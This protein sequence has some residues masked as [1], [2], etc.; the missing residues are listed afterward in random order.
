[1]NV[2]C[3][4][5]L[6]VA[7]AGAI[8]ISCDDKGNELSLND[9]KDED[10]RR[11]ADSLALRDSLKIAYYRDSVELAQELA[12]KNAAGQVNYSVV[13]VNGSA[14]S[15]FS[16]GRTSGTQ[17]LDGAT[18]SVSQ[19]GTVYSETTDAT[20]IASFKGFLRG[21][22]V[23]SVVRDGFTSLNYV[24]HVPGD[25]LTTTGTKTELGNMVPIFEL[26]GE[27]TATVS[28]KLTVDTDLTNKISEAVPE[29]TTITAAIDA[30]DPGFADKFFKKDVVG[31]N[32]NPYTANIYSAV[33]NSNVIGSTNADGEYTITIPSAVDGLPMKFAYSQIAA[34]QKLFESSDLGLNNVRSYR[35]L[36]GPGIAPT[37]VPPAGGV[38]VNILAGSGASATAQISEDGKVERIDVVR[39]GYGYAGT[40]V[41]QVSPSPTPGGI[42]ATASA[43]VV[44][45]VITAITLD[46]PGT[47]YTTAPTVSVEAGSGAS[48]TAAL[49]GTTSVLSARITNSG[50]GYTTAPNVTFTA[51]PGTGTTATGTAN[52]SN[53][54]VTS[55]TI[56]DAGSGYDP[57]AL[58]SITIDAPPAGG[59][60]A[61]AVALSSGS[62]VDRV[63]VLNNGA[64]YPYAPVVTFSAPDLVNG[65]RA[66]GVA[67]YDANIQGVVGVEITNPGSGYTSAPSIAFNPGTGAVLQ[68]KFVGRGV[69]SVT[70]NDGGTKYSAAPLV[71]FEPAPGSGG[72]G[73]AGTAVVVN[74]EVVAVEITSA[75]NGYDA[76]PLISFVSGQDGKAYAVVDDGKVT[77]I[78]LVDGGFGYT[79]APEIELTA[80]GG[81][82]SGATATATVSDGVITAINVTNGGGA[83]IGGNTPA[84]S[85][86]FAGG[87]S[88]NSVKPGIRYVHDLYYGTG[89]TQK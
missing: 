31:D 10:A 3:K 36:F 39:G 82:G 15:F 85:V 18:V 8:V 77:E 56:T 84:A 62:P 9:L 73:A 89:A 5:A 43:T 80:I 72:S 25:I 13:V 46:N 48:A 88:N 61:S 23:V 24:A 87:Y 58:P 21:A 45:G 50:S 59:T 52:I 27:N 66:Q 34:S 28:G 65:V 47:G 42:D 11:F 60:Q 86:G 6:V 37:P 16:Q 76:A 2:L 44:N 81:S 14:S 49:S 20:G 64:N 32:A 55:I 33:Y 30:S 71:V 17:N 22:I 69:S 57:G 4:M 70:I 68:A 54:K 19:F 67:I 7:V 74:G 29:G 35:S 63:S 41:I 1:M 12:Q 51:A 53:G 79:G 38:G 78:R 75:G 40:P 83:Y 26:S